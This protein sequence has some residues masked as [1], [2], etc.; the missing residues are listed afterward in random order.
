MRSLGQLGGQAEFQTMLVEMLNRTTLSLCMW[1]S[2]D[3]DSR[4][5]RC[6]ELVKEMMGSRLANFPLSREGEGLIALSLWERAGLGNQSTQYSTTT[7]PRI[8]PSSTLRCASV[9][10]S[11]LSPC[12][13]SLSELSHH[14]VIHQLR[15]LI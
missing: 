12:S 3:Y 6:V 4:F 13:V 5:L 9:M 15:R 7:F 11:T 8:C 14:A 1:K 10:L 2:P